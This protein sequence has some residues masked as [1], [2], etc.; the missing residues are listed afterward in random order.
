MNTTRKC[1]NSHFYHDFCERE[2]F[3]D[4]IGTFCLNNALHV[5]YI[6]LCDIMP[7]FESIDLHNCVISKLK[8]GF[9]YDKFLT[10]LLTC[11]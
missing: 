6:L 4:R 9:K 11:E 2:L 7:S 8:K 5:S 3:I 1:P 10:N